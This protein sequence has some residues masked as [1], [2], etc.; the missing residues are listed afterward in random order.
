MKFVCA[1]MVVAIHCRW[2]WGEPWNPT[3][4]AN[5]TLF[6]RGVT[7]IAVPF[8]FVCSGY[9]IARH[10]TSLSAWR[11]AVYK[12]IKTIVVP[13][14]IWTMIEILFFPLVVAFFGDIV[15]GRPVCSTPCAFLRSYDWI[16]PFEKLFWKTP[17]A[18][19]WYLRCL[20]IFVLIAPAIIFL[21]RR[22]GKT[23]LMF[24]FLLGIFY[25]LLP[26]HNINMLLGF[27]FSL[28]GLFY[29][30]LGIWLFNHPLPIFGGGG[31]CFAVAALLFSVKMIL[32]SKGWHVGA[33][34]AEELSIPFLLYATWRMIP[35]V[36]LPR[37]LANSFFPIYLMHMCAIWSLDSLIPRVPSLVNAPC[38]CAL[39][40]L[41]VGVFGSIAGA[42]ILRR[43]LP[44]VA[45][46]VFGER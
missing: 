7:R 25:H 28:P 22:R 41:F 5:Q 23:Y 32:S 8:F 36:R 3:W 4:I 38:V 43:L 19:L 12:R 6:L 34:M 45:R 15:L 33:L 24:C 37:W 20:F 13:F 27:N 1:V 31:Q 35:A 21:I 40:R 10:L 18:P 44:N 11:S 42:N 26:G 30:S 17:I 14:F 16:Y 9:F 46:V 29:F 2:P 39:I